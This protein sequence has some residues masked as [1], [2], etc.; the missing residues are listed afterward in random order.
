MTR[1]AG[2]VAEREAAVLAEHGVDLESL[3]IPGVRLRGARRALR[4]RPEGACLEALEDTADA[5]RLCFT[6][7]SG[8]YATVLVEALFGP[9]EEV[10][11]NPGSADARSE[12]AVS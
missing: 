2:A 8:S 9:F 6:L 11:G 1:P 4:C 5:A 10:R 3:R 7:P 12:R